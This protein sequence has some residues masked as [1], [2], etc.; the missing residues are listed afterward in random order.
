MWYLTVGNTILMLDNFATYVSTVGEQ[1]AC[2]QDRRLSA[3]I[4]ETAK[5]PETLILLHAMRFRMT[6]L[7]SQ[8]HWNLICRL[9]PL[10]PP[11]PLILFFCCSCFCHL[12]PHDLCFLPILIIINQFLLHLHILLMNL[13]GSIC[14]L[15][16]PAFLNH[17]CSFH[18]LYTC[19]TCMYH[20]CICSAVSVNF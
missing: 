12:F 20:V 10:P 18:C 13:Y 6:N 17:L 11:P 8:C 1:A 19:P 16:F 7:H 15:T 14:F 9:L 5:P 2:R 3:L 4:M